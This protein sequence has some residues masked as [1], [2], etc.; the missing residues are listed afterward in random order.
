MQN[1]DYT[2]KLDVGI[3]PSTDRLYI[4]SNTWP[5]SEP[6]LFPNRY[7]RNDLQVQPE[8]LWQGEALFVKQY[9][10]QNVRSQKVTKLENIT[11]SKWANILVIGS[12]SHWLLSGSQKT[13]TFNPEIGNRLNHLH[14]QL[15]LSS[16]RWYSIVRHWKILDFCIKIHKHRRFTINAVATLMH[17]T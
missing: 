8:V 3:W 15:K 7:Y 12:L 13:A 1:I 6:G 9:D 14:Y 4:H 17:T 11:L 2:P 16:R 10:S 5:F